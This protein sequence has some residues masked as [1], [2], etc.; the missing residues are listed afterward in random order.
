[1]AVT[2]YR[3]SE[4]SS[5]FP[6]A[7]SPSSTSL[8]LLLGLGPEGVLESVMLGGIDG[9]SALRA[10]PTLYEDSLRDDGRGVRRIGV[11]Q[12]GS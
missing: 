1:M 10:R 4:Y 7:A 11:D 6:T 8:T 9:L 2:M 5:T 12:A 3:R